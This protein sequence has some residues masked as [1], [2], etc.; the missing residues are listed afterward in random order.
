MC[1]D[2]QCSIHHLQTGQLSPRDKQPLA[3]RPAP[4]PGLA[5]Q[6]RGMEV[7]AATKRQSCLWIVARLCEVLRHLVPIAP[8]MPVTRS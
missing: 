2:W 6:Q 7:K 3:A 4:T 5:A 8:V 1:W